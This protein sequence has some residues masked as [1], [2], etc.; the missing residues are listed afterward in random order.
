MASRKKKWFWIILVLI[1]L[2]VALPM[3]LKKDKLTVVES[4]KTVRRTIVKTI[5]ASGVIEPVK[6]VNIS[7][8]I[9]ANLDSLLVSEGQT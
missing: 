6:N 8:E 2:S 1:I 4:D 3:I 7:S 9:S 5:S